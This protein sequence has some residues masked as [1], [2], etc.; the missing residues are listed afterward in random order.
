DP[1]GS[2]P[3]LDDGT[4]RATGLLDV[5]LD[6]LDDAS[7]PGVVE[8]CDVV[9]GAQVAITRP[10]V[11]RSRAGP[12]ASCRNRSSGAARSAGRATRGRRRLVTA[13]RPPAR[14]PGSPARLSRRE[15]RRLPVALQP[16]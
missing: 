5:E 4:A 9:V 8:P 2:D 10:S 1:A 11:A 16:V 7:R 14:P 12:R 6:V 13:G 3:E 15:A